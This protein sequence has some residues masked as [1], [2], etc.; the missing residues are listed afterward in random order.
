MMEMQPP[1]YN[2]ALHSADLALEVAQS[3]NIWR[4][5]AKTQRLRGHC[6]KG[7]GR[8]RQAYNCYVRGASVPDASENVE[9]LTM[10][11]LKMMEHH[12]DKGRARKPKLRPLQHRSSNRVNKERRKGE[13]TPDDVEDKVEDGESSDTA[14]KD[15]PRLRRV[16]GRKDDAWY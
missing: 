5:E 6:F 15:A 9:A 4:L 2:L 13:G 16:S 1:D 14:V 11:C 10:E 8:W 12:G 3:H 7:M